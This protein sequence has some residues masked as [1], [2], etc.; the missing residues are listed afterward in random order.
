M[1]KINFGRVILAGFAAGL[2][3]LFVEIILEGS[4]R[5]I[6]GICESKM[7][8][9]AFNIAPSGILFHILN[10]GIFF[11]ICILIMWVYAAIRPRF[12]SNA[13]AAIVTS[14]IFWLFAFL[15]TANHIN[16]GIFPL[17]L[18]F[19]NMGFNLIELPVAILV[20]S[21]LYKE[22]RNYIKEE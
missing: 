8:Q 9:E 22:A 4:V 2:T 13:K 1:K 10:I 17:D 15:F 14:L 18:Y 16:L 11:M 7:F 21:Y 5:L 6:F 20:G 12:S 19:L 3:F